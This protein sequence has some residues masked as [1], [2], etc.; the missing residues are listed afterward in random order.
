MK[1]ALKI[2]LLYKVK[3]EDNRPSPQLVTLV[4]LDDHTVTTVISVELRVSAI[5][6]SRHSYLLDAMKGRNAISQ[7]GPKSELITNLGCA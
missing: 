1:V 5:L 3:K 6:Q 4:I 7:H 2:T